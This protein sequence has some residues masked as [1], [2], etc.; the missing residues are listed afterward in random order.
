ML[1]A[2]LEVLTVKGL[3]TLGPR[4]LGP[5][6]WGTLVFLVAML[7]LLIN[8]FHFGHKKFRYELLYSLYN[9]LVAPFGYVR[10]KD[11]FLGDILTSLVKPLVDMMFISCYFTYP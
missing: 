10:F 9:T 1:A 7:L 5:A 3:V 11:F 6:S 8:P 4:D 2:L